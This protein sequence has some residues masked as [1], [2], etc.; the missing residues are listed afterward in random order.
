MMSRQM[1][2]LYVQNIIENASDGWNLLFLNLL[3]SS[4]CHADNQ[5]TCADYNTF[6]KVRI[7]RF[8]SRFPQNRHTGHFIGYNLNLLF[9][10]TDAD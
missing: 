7:E 5:T 10:L 3:Q 6:F 4:V 1:T 2:T 8:S 9:H